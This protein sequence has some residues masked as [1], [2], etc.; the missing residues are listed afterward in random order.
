MVV[1]ARADVA[2]VTQ[3]DLGGGGD[4]GSR[5]RCRPAPADRRRERLPPPVPLPVN[6]VNAPALVVIVAEPAVLPLLSERLPLFSQVDAFSEL[7]TMPA[8]VR[9]NA[10]PGLTVRM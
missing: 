7:L 10:T 2:V 4:V 6:W 5:C 1:G 8:P 3:G 9:L